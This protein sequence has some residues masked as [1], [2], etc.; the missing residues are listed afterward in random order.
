MSLVC[1]AST[2]AAALFNEGLDPGVR[3]MVD[4]RADLVAVV[5]F[6]EAQEAFTHVRLEA[7]G[8][9]LRLASWRLGRL[10]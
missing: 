8:E 3:V 4:D 5:C 7:T 1:A 6:A 9:H 2:P 10:G